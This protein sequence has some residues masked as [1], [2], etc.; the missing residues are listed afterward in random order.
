M[1]TNFLNCFEQID[2]LN[3]KINGCLENS[4]DLIKQAKTAFFM[5][6]KIKEIN[7]NI[8]SFNYMKAKKRF[9]RVK[10]RENEG[11]YLFDCSV[12]GCGKKYTT[13]ENLNLHISNVHLHVKPYN[14]SFCKKIFSHRN[15]KL[16]IKSKEK[17]TMKGKN[18]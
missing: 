7:N 9:K 14:C 13:K 2:Y 18:T 11:K 16:L 6:E 17:S 8:N 5:I 3:S 1:I 12:K 15:G 10:L 4:C